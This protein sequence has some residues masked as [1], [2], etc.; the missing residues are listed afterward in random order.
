[1]SLLRY[2]DAFSAKNVNIHGMSSNKWTTKDKITQ[3]KGLVNLYSKCFLI[4]NV[5]GGFSARTLA[6]ADQLETLNLF[7]FL[8]DRKRS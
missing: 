6:F 8:V 5:F 4:L 1:M 3:F 2:P 7:L